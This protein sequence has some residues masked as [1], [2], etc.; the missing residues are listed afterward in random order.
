MTDWFAF[1]PGQSL[2][3]REMNK[4]AKATPAGLEAR[5]YGRPEA[6]RYTVAA[7]VPV[8]VKGGFRPTG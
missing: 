5:L 4:R 7:V 8:A 2:W 1:L 6:R 3:M